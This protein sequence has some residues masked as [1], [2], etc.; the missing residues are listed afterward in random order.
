[1]KKNNKN[2]ILE[3]STIQRLMTGKLI[4]EQWG[5]IIDDV[6][7]IGSK[8]AGKLPDNVDN[9]ISRLSKVANEEDAIKILADIAKQSDEMA[10]IIVPKIML[11]ISDVERKT[12]NDIKTLYK[13]GIA[14]GLDPDTAKSSAENWVN[15]NVKTKFDG[16]KDIIKKDILDYIDNVARKSPPTPKPIV[17]NPKPKNITDVA[18]QNWE[19]IVPLTS[20]ELTKLE[21]LYRQ[22]GL[23]QS[24]FRSMRQFSQTITDMFTK[25]VELMDE[26]LSLMKTLDETE[27][28]AQKTD[29]LKRIGDNIR[30][31]TKSDVDNYKIID[32]WIDTNVPD[33]KLKRKLEGIEGYQKAAKIFDGGALK[34]WKENYKGLKDRRTSMMI[35]ANSMLNP[36]SWFPGIMR[37]KFG[38]SGGYGAQ[39]AKK[40]LTF[41][42]GPEYGEFRRFLYSGQTQKWKG[43]GDFMKEFGIIP[44]LTNVAKEFAWSYISLA[45]MYAFVDYVTDILGNQVRNVEY[46]ND[47]GF[48]QN[49]I[50][51]Y[52]EHINKENTNINTPT[53]SAIGFLNFLGD[54]GNY[55]MDYFKDLD[56]V[57]PGLA[58]DFW[59]FWFGVRNDNISEENADKLNKQGEKL[60]EQIKTAQKKLEN[61]N[62][63]TS[64]IDIEKDIKP[65][66]PC[67][68]EGG[69][70]V[71]LEKVDGKET[72][73]TH[74]S[75]WSEKYYLDVVKNN[76]ITTVYYQDTNQ[77][78]CK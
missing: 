21:K 16:V 64:E 39:V 35:Q 24:F 45:V 29:I 62:D 72:Y 6:I 8:I 69:W 76:N 33:Y 18:G 68:F 65:V 51:S 77:N 1:M 41:V 74:N 13:N 11:T 70:D 34:T 58:D 28:A 5:S 61:T 56:V 32:E 48:V 4:L 47:Y 54:M 71:S 10:G 53:K 57:I 27:N 19:Q 37:R 31:L 46:L 43:I 17:D 73:V 12:I 44:G 52:D 36:L 78:P 23:G 40:W 67:L 50:K 20:D 63:T 25:Q 42:K 60:K 14:D 9:L 2:L 66:V 49:Q 59:N 38:D 30:N 22:K 15:Q 3:I 55:S 7:K 26:T 75:D